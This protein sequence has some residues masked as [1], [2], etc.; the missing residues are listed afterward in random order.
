MADTTNTGPKKIVNP[1]APGAQA[2][3]QGKK[4]GGG[5]MFDDHDYTA[6]PGQKYGIPK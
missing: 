6:A 2:A 4:S 3:A 5:M 1:M